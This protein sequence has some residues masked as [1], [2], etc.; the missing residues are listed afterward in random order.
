M[1]LVC[2]HGQVQTGLVESPSYGA[3]PSDAAQEGASEAK[4]WHMVTVGWMCSSD[5]LLCSG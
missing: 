2:H 1:G 3:G 5:L 4:G